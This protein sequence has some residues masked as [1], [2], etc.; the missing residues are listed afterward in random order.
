MLVYMNLNRAIELLMFP[1][2]ADA[3]ALRDRRAA[4]GFG[5]RF[6]TLEDVDV[7]NHFEDDDPHL[8]ALELLEDTYSLTDTALLALAPRDGTVFTREALTA[9]EELTEELWR[10]PYCHSRRLHFEPLAQRRI[11]G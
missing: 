5:G 4:P 7:R 1:Q 2:V 10:T 11:R 6:I 3:A 9:I 8:V